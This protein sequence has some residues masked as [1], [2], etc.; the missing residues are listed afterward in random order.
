M[1]RRPPRS[2]QSR[3]SAASDVY[4]RQ[5][6]NQINRSLG[7]RTHMPRWA[8]SVVPMKG[9]AAC[10][11]PTSVSVYCLEPDGDPTC[12]GACCSDVAQLHG[13]AVKHPTLAGVPRSSCAQTLLELSTQRVGAV[14][15]LNP[16]LSVAA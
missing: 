7:Q 11:E 15:E 4:K 13:D 9:R 8:R 14:L 6:L 12:S 2:T 10:G 5:R 16:G 3:S 1:I